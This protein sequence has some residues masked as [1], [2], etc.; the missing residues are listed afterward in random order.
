MTQEALITVAVTLLVVFA[1]CG[2]FETGGESASTQTVE[3]TSTPID[4]SVP[5]A[6]S[7]PN[8]EVHP[9]G[10]SDT[11][12]QNTTLAL[13]SHYR[14]MFAGPSTTV[15]YRSRVSTAKADQAINTTL[16]MKVHPEKQ[17][18]H[19]SV[20]GTEYHREVFFS[21]GTFTAW[22]VRNETV[23]GQSRVPFTRASR[24]IDSRI[25][26]SHLLLYKLDLN[27]T[28]RRDG[29]TARV[30]NVT[31]VYNGTFSQRHGS[32][33]SGSGHVVVSESGRILDIQTTVTYTGRTVSYRYQQTKIGETE[34][35]A[36]SGSKTHDIPLL[37][38]MAISQ[39]CLVP[40]GSVRDISD[41]TL[42]K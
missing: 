22:S 31:G 13:K 17:R 35:D 32:A 3:A 10:W 2:S 33:T 21:D 24:S 42:S 6:T 39:R 23:V 38:V 28:V 36:P 9:R 1:G 27:D 12:I 4:S 18:F 8:A 41:P 16:D 15:S 37:S 26:K 34:V 19:A 40:V 14:T 5:T 29:T 30:Y 7:S 20:I 25:L 11:G